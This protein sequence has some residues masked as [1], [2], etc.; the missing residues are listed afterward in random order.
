MRVGRISKINVV[1]RSYHCAR[2]DA[3]GMGRDDVVD[4]SNSDVS[5][6]AVCRVSGD[7]V[8]RQEYR[9]AA[10][11]VNAAATHGCPR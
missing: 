6:H 2:A 7:R 10:V 11:D 5:V 9:P 1:L 3:D 8:I 4:E